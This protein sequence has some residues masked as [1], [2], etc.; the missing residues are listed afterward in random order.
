MRWSERIRLTQNGY[1]AVCRLVDERDEH[2]CIVCRRFFN[3]EDT[4]AEQVVDHHHVM[5][6]SAGGSDTEDNLVCLCRKH[7]MELA[8]GNDRW[9][10]KREFQKYL[11][12]E[13]CREW[14][15]E[16]AE[17]LNELYERYRK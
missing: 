14:R 3:F 5:F 17:E 1:H 13:Y 2:F 6:R 9:H 4:Y 10:W 7:H 12:S 11:Q 8:H 16:H 15:E